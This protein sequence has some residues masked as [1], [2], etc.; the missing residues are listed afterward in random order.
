MRT[1]LLLAVFLTGCSEVRLDCAP[2]GQDSCWA[3]D[4]DCRWNV[5]S[6]CLARCDPADE[7]SCQSPDVCTLAGFKR[8]PSTVVVDENPMENL[9]VDMSQFEGMGGSS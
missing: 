4:A 8:P 3:H 2:M 7:E 6:G 1:S 9:C 5:I